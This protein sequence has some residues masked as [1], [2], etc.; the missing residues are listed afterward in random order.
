MS[1]I[2]NEGD[3]DVDVDVDVDDFLLTYQNVE[4]MIMTVTI[5]RRV[6]RITTAT[7][8]VDVVMIMITCKRVVMMML[9]TCKRVGHQQIARFLLSMQF[10]L[11][12]SDT[13][14]VEMMI[15]M[16]AVLMNISIY[17]IDDF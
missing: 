17:H 4:R 12:C 6:I 7:K 10:T 8:T 15:L 5:F 1:K 3:V 11:D 14:V 2:H 9:I 13:L 16:A